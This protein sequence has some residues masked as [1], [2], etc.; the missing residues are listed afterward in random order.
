MEAFM[1]VLTG[2]SDLFFKRALLI[3]LHM[4]MLSGQDPELASMASRFVIGISPVL[5]IESVFLCLR[6]Y[7]SCQGIMV[8]LTVIAAVRAFVTP[9]AN[10]LMMNVLE[11]GID[12]ACIAY[13]FSNTTSLAIIICIIWIHGSRWQDPLR[14]TWSKWSESI[15]SLAGFQQ[16]LRVSLPSMALVCANWW[17]FEALILITGH[18]ANAKV[19]IAVMGVLFNTHHLVYMINYGFAAAATTRMSNLLGKTDQCL[20]KLLFKI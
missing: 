11:L 10:F 3:Q 8:P 20:P 15:S 14:R 13:A 17:V 5:L 19:Q 1:E 2:S 18:R 4:F 6:N 9:T 16:C 12:G 7:L